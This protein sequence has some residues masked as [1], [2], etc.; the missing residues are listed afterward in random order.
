MG[1]VRGRGLLTLLRP[2]E[3]LALVERMVD[4][5]SRVVRIVF[6]LNRVWQP[7]SSGSRTGPRRWRT[8]PNAW[9][10][11]SRRR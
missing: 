2:G 3:R 7:T 1:R 8:S 6:A 5:A 10:S 9:P 11:G 4:D